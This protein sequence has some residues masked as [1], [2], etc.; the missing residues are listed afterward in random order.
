MI[1]HLSIKQI[2]EI[3]E[4]EARIFPNNLRDSKSMFEKRF[5]LGHI[6]IGFR[7]TDHILQGYTAFSYGTFH[8]DFSAIPEHY[9]LWSTQPIPQSFNTAF[10]YGLCI[11]KNKKLKYQALHSLTHHSFLQAKNDGCSQSIIEM[12]I[13]SYAGNEYCKPNPEITNYL[14]Q[15]QVGEPINSHI[16][17]KDGRLNL[18]KKLCSY[19]IIAIKHN[20]INDPASGNYRIF[21]LHSLTDE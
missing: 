3:L 10:M 20:F 12:A 14:N 6:F 16:L 4:L 13:P 17:L 1:E 19:S 15:Y 7:C 9:N 11:T 21:V 8:T 18:L 2:D 5:Q